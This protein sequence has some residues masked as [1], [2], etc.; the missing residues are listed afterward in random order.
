MSALAALTQRHLL[1]GRNRP[2]DRPDTG[3]CKDSPPP[4][5]RPNL[6]PTPDSAAASWCKSLPHGSVGQLDALASGRL[7]DKPS[8]PS[9]QLTSLH[10]VAAPAPLEARSLPP[11]R[12][13]L[14]QPNF[15]S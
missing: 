10:L 6:V 9:R 1:V 13:P 11:S 5:P 15:T 14:S 7:P 8:S 4:P 12:T 3:P 2:K